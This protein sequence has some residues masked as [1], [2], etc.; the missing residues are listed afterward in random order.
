M[1][2]PRADVVGIG[3]S[4]VDLVFRVPVYPTPHGDLSK[5]PI[6]SHRVSCGGQTATTLCTC[7]SLG[8]TSLYVGTMGSDQHARLMRETLDGRGVDTRHA[9]VRDGAHPYAVIVIAEDSGERVVLWRREPALALRPDDLEAEAIRGSRLL[10][11]DDVDLPAA[12]A[13]CRERRR[14][15]SPDREVIGRIPKKG[16]ARTRVLDIAVGGKVGLDLEVHC[17]RLIDQS[18]GHPNRLV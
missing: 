11:V 9:L 10:H 7:A 16:A 13:A 1:P 4:S 6:L 14:G 12:L 17:N 2:S 5:V 3:A 15:E 8:L 18:Q